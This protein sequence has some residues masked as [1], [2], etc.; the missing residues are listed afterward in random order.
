MTDTGQKCDEESVGHPS[1]RLLVWDFSTYSC[2]IF[3]LLP[4]TVTVWLCNVVLWD[5]SLYS[6]EWGICAVNRQSDR[7]ALHNTAPLILS[8]KHHIHKLLKC[9]INKMF[10]L[11]RKKN[12]GLYRTMG[13]KSWYKQNFDFGVLYR[14]SPSHDGKQ[15]DRRGILYSCLPFGPTNLL[16]YS[17]K[18]NPYRACIWHSCFHFQCV[19]QYFS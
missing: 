17:F 5:I 2:G 12:W 14:Y 19:W 9:F 8:D 4:K 15:F 18:Q 7:H 1:Y 3:N 13:K 6:V 11:E 10:D 16:S